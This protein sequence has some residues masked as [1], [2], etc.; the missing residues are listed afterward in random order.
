[1]LWK[2]HPIYDGLDIGNYL[3]DLKQEYLSRPAHERLQLLGRACACEFLMQLRSQSAFRKKRIPRNAHRILWI[4]DEADLGNSIMDLSQRFALPP[5]MEVDLCMTTGPV[6]LFQGD[7]RFAHVFCKLEECAEAYDFVILHSFNLPT[8]RA[9]IRRYPCVP[10]ASILDYQHGKRF[11]RVEISA[12]RLGRLMGKPI[13]PLYRPSIALSAP[14]RPAAPS[15]NV[16][17]ALGYGADNTVYPHWHELLDHICQ[18]WKAEWP[19]LKITLIGKDAAAH[20]ALRRIP[21]S[22]LSAHCENLLDGPDLQETVRLIATG[23][24]FLSASNGLVQIAE[25]LCKPGLCLFSGI[26]PEWRLIPGS[27]LHALYSGHDIGQIP[28]QTIAEHIIAQAGQ[29][30]A[31]ETA[32]SRAPSQAIYG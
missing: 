28:A 5:G 8:L 1:M 2:T 24:L 13:Q 17:V 31:T 12:I 29:C 9:K 15:G 4:Y 14:F 20:E 23:D 32:A 7:S 22:F 21:Q 18:T 6:E 16:T 3:N 26:H 11:A 10:F 30:Y 19:Q 25:A 27:T